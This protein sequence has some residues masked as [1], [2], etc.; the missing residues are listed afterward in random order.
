MHMQA[1]ES[2]AA[3]VGQQCRMDVEDAVV[4]DRRDA[5]QDVETSEAHQID[6][7]PCERFGDA[8]V[9]LRIAAAGA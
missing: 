1:I 7:M 8:V 5:V 9:E 4:E 2:P 3:E 6:A